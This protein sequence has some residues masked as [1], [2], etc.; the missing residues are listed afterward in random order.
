MLNVV[1]L[2]HPCVIEE[3]LKNTHNQISFFKSGS[4]SLIIAKKC[5]VQV[6][7]VTQNKTKISIKTISMA[8]QTDSLKIQPRTFLKNPFRNVYTIKRLL[9]IKTNTWSSF[10]AD[11]SS[12][13]SV[14]YKHNNF[15]IKISAKIF[16]RKY[17]AQG[18]G[19]RQ[20]IK[21]LAFQFF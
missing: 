13:I 10:N 20:N 15:T 8:D 17:W 16:Q 3:Y 2:I 11:N 9:L 4:Q 12:K 5:V 14:Q 19:V 21:M 18:K 1:F 6:L 7:H